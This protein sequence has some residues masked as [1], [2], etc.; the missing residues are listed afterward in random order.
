MILENTQISDRPLSFIKVIRDPQ[1]DKYEW[2][3]DN[4]MRKTT[5]ILKGKSSRRSQYKNLRKQSAKFYRVNKVDIGKNLDMNSS[6]KRASS[7]YSRP[8]SRKIAS[9]EKLKKFQKNK[10]SK[11]RSFEYRKRSKSVVTVQDYNP[12]VKIFFEKF[13]NFQN[14]LENIKQKQKISMELMKKKYKKVKK[15]KKISCSFTKEGKCNLVKRNISISPLEIKRINIKRKRQNKEPSM[16][17]IKKQLLLKI[18]NPKNF[19]K[20][21]NKKFGE[22]KNRDFFLMK[23]TESRSSMIRDLT[24]YLLD[25]SEKALK[26]IKIE[27]FWNFKGKKFLEEEEGGK[28]IC[29]RKFEKLEKKFFFGE[30]EKSEKNHYKIS[31]YNLFKE[32][33]PKFCI[34]DLRKYLKKNTKQMIKS[35]DLKNFQLKVLLKM[36][37]KWLKFQFFKN[38]FLPFLDVYKQRKFSF[39]KRLEFYKNINTP[40]FEEYE[41]KVGLK[42]ATNI[43]YFEF[44]EVNFPG[45]GHKRFEKRYEINFVRHRFE[46]FLVNLRNKIL[47][48]NKELKDQKE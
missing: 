26:E 38:I 16:K 27:P 48:Y 10:F 24:T 21:K 42:E 8:Y 37:P 44:E 15:R 17:K 28:I 1:T 11:L 30:Y 29:S 47:E 18:K 34:L 31:L 41:K 2:D 14:S 25:Y 23:K 7:S 4:K 5:G 33:N 19:V 36:K 20:K 6:Y 39:L 43:D 35:L 13:Q 32:V 40:G 22:K 46:N 45:Y 3:K 12:K 9:V